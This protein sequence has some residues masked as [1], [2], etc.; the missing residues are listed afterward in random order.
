MFG[1]VVVTKLM[2]QA[3]EQEHWYNDG[4]EHIFV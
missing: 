1:Y 4:L 3:V 2:A